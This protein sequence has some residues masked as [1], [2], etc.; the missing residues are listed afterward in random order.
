MAEMRL[1]LGL[2]VYNFDFKMPDEFIGWAEGQRSYQLWARG[3]LDMYLTPA[4]ST[5]H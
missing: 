4:S 5:T 1:I 3:P 2:L